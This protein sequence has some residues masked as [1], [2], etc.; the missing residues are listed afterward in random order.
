M[1]RIVVPDTVKE[2]EKLLDE[3]LE[4]LDTKLRNDQINQ[5]E[6]RKKRDSLFLQYERFLVAAGYKNIAERVAEKEDL[7]NYR[8]KARKK[9]RV[10]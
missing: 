10:E 4:A 9:K 8:S 7:Q 3:E 5:R 2:A 6:H 1:A